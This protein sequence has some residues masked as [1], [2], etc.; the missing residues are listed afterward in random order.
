MLKVKHPN[1]DVNDKSLENSTVINSAKS[2]ELLLSDVSYIPEDGG[3]RSGWN[4]PLPV[5]EHDSGS[6]PS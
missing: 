5:P 6:Q 2:R 1:P 3:W 4:V